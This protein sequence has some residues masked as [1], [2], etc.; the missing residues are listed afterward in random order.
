MGTA[1]TMACIAEALGMTVP[2]GA[3]PPAVT[4]DR[5]RVAEETGRIAV[6]MARSASPSTRSSRRKAF[7][8]ALRVLLAIG[9]STNAIVHL[10]AIAGRW[11]T[12]WT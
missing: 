6:Q 5:M 9:G 10:T 7:E 1:S 12:S 4:A 8:N 11:A 3:T 2:G